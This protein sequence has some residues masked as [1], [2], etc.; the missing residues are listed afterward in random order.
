MNGKQIATQ[1]EETRQDTHR[2]LTPVD[3]GRLTTQHDPL[4]SPLVWDYAHIGVFE[5]LWL[6]QNLSSGERVD[7]DLLHLYNAVEN[8]RHT[9]RRLQLM[10]RPRTL[11]YLEDVRGR[12]L[13][14]MEELDPDDER[15]PNHELLRGG[16]VYDLVNQHERQHQETICQTLQLLPGGYLSE[17]PPTPPGRQAAHDMVEIP[18]GRYPIGSDAHEPYDNEGPRH[19]VQLDGF[20]I[21]RFPV[22]NGEYLR[23][24]EDG[25]YTRQELWCHNGWDWAMTFG[26]EAP[27]YW[28]RRDG[29]WTV[30]RFGLTGPVPE[31]EPVVHVCYFEADAYA[32]WAGKRL[33]TEFE[34]E[35][36]AAWDPATGSKRRFPWAGG[37]SNGDRANLGTWRFHPAAAGAY[38]EGASPSG[39][40]Q[41]MGDVW[42]WTSSDFQPY[43]GFRPFPYEE[44]SQPFFGT[45]FKVL[46]GGS[47]A[48]H[49][50]VARATFRNWDS[51]IK[52]PIFAG[53]RC[54]AD[55]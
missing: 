43:P 21:D 53:F 38:P 20:R 10:D 14:L 7:E 2:L 49:P 31:E 12:V 23:F 45:G 1:L 9:R 11:A 22:T 18:A 29:S 5:E 25:G 51:P 52:R 3:D 8:P 33:P 15:D 28:R 48:T 36:A 54:A 6:L 44:Y 27:E 17:L 24:M 16:F 13:N 19:E 26:V 4:L 32:R 55:L 42:E 34:W 40:E 50:S 37:D 39:C 35:V 47:W 30:D 41:M 46:R